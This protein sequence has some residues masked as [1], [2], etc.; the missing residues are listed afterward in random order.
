MLAYLVQGVAL[1][2]AAAVSPGGF[3]AF[4]LAHTSQ[5]GFR[6]T[7]Y[8]AFAPLLSD[9]PIIVLMLLIV[10]QMPGAILRLIQIA[11]GLFLFY[12][13][14]DAAR[15]F[16]H[17]APGAARSTEQS[18]FKA[19]LVNALGPGPY[20]FWGSVAGPVLIR[21]WAQSPWHAAGFMLGFYVLLIGGFVGFVLLFAT[22]G[23]LGP[24]VARTLTGVS[25]LALVGLGVYQIWSGILTR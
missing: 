12:L 22:A 16:I 24:R 13:A 14:W 3:Q 10:T 5:H 23:R 15:A 20:I 21:A 8:M 1:G 18:I 7:W 19:A 25:A 17:Y 6:Q 4:L 2:F 11:G 9:G